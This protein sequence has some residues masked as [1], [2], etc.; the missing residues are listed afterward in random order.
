MWFNL[1]KPKMM[2][3]FWK[4][5]V[6]PYEPQGGHSAAMPLPMPTDD[7]YPEPH[8]GR[9]VLKSVILWTAATLGVIIL[10]AAVLIIPG[11][12]F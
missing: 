4:S 9:G 7:D 8:T 2:S 3:E 6:D 1:D 5:R 11:L 10:L 12:V